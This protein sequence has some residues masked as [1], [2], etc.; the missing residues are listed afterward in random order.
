MKKPDLP[1]VSLESPL[2]RTYRE[3]ARKCMSPI[4]WFRPQPPFE[5]LHSG[6][7]TVVQTDSRVFGI[8]ARHVLD[9]YF[10]DADATKDVHVQIWDQ[11]IDQIKVIDCSETRDLATIELD[12]SLVKVLELEP[13]KWPP[14]LP[15]EKGGLIL[16]GYPGVWREQLQHPMEVDWGIFSAITRARTVTA[17]Q[18]TVLISREEWAE[19]TLPLNC[20]LG[21]I[22]GG[23]IIGIFDGPIFSYGLCGIIKEQPDYINSYFSIE[24]IVGT[25]AHFISESGQIY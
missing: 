6:T 4:M 22:S 1:H 14:R 15:T 19:N 24:R 20:N 16:A 12:E 13:L 18:V 3:I 23:P 11:R 9:E 10:R 25:L 5:I 17:D 2:G 7:I 8:T 21:G